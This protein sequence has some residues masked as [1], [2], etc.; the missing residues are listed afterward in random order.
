L[1]TPPLSRVE[2]EI[3]PCKNSGSDS[4]GGDGVLAEVGVAREIASAIFCDLA[5]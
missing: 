3:T 2:G 4:A 1:K 5:R